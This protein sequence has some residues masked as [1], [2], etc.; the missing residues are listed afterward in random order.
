ML[1]IAR[2]FDMVLNQSLQPWKQQNF[3]ATRTLWICFNSI[4][5]QHQNFVYIS[6]CDVQSKNKWISINVYLSILSFHTTADEYSNVAQHSQI[7]T[8]PVKSVLTL[9]SRC[10][11]NTNTHDTRLD[12]EKC[13]EYV[14]VR[15]PLVCCS[16]SLLQLCAVI[17]PNHYQVCLKKF[18]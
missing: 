9:P 8:V 11:R 14:L 1:Y 4:F 18:W 3:K 13:I 5:Y 7:S 12:T 16:C 6:S 17:E 15:V 2:K 10:G